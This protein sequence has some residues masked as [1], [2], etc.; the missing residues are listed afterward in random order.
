MFRVA[1]VSIDWIELSSIQQASAFSTQS[2]NYKPRVLKEKAQGTL[3]WMKCIR[4]RKGARR[5]LGKPRWNKVRS[6]LVFS[7]VDSVDH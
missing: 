2:R 3:D 1:Q 7:D 6:T 5:K 4:V